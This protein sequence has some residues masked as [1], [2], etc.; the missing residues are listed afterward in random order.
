MFDVERRVNM[1]RRHTSITNINNCK[2]VIAR[3]TMSAGC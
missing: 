1:M 2:R 3:T